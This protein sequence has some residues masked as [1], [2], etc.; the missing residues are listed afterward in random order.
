MVRYRRSKKVGPFRFTL[1]QAGISTSVGAGPLRVTRSANGTVRRTVRVPGTG[2]YDT[3][4]VGG[5]TQ[6]PR[7]TAADPVSAHVANLAVELVKLAGFLLLF[8]IIVSA[9]TGSVA[10]GFGIVGVIV[11]GLLVALA[12][13]TV[14]L[15][16]RQTGPSDQPSPEAKRVPE[17][18]TL[19]AEAQTAEAEARAAE[20]RARAIRLQME[21]LGKAKPASGPRSSGKSEGRSSTAQLRTT[22][23]AVPSQHVLASA[24][25][26][27][28][29]DRVKVVAPGDNSYLKDGT[30]TEFLNGSEVG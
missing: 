26:M 23:E 15:T 11:V 27:R 19:E 21:S 3:K 30:V 13:L 5:A 22:A 29:G 25:E 12:G 4:V 20:A 10:V 16:R 2:V 1:T 28:I 6:R 9:L 8:G 17:T 14:K 7:P 18:A 24:T